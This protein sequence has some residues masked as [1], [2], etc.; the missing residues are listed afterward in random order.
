M[1]RFLVIRSNENRH[2]LRRPYDQISGRA[3]AWPTKGL[4]AGTLYG[5]T[6][7]GRSVLAARQDR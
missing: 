6:P 5:D 1:L 3:P 7:L 2:G 4:F